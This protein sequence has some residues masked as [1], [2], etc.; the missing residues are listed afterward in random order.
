VVAALRADVLV[1]GLVQHGFTQLG[2]L[3]HRR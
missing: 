1:F 3:I 2:H